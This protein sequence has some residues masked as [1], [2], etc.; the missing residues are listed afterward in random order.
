MRFFE[1][2]EQFEIELGKKIS[3][4]KEYEGKVKGEAYNKRYLQIV[5]NLNSL[6]QKAMK[7][8][9]DGTI[10]HIHGVRHRPHRKN[11]RVM[12][13]ESFNLYF[14]NITEQE[15]PILVK[16]HVKNAISYTIS[17]ITPGLIITS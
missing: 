12:V 6:K 8:G 4:E 7:Y 13:K 1:I 16:L 5:E 15:A 10:C 9:T 2:N 11:N 3:L 14:S 17:F